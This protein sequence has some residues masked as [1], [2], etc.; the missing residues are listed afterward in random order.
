VIFQN[1]SPTRSTLFRNFPTCSELSTTP[2]PAGHAPPRRGW[3]WPIG[4]W[5]WWSFARSCADGLVAMASVRSPAPPGWTGRRL[6]CT[7][8][9]H[10]RRAYSGVALAARPPLECSDIC[11]DGQGDE[12]S[13][14]HPGAGPKPSQ[15]ASERT[16]R[17]ARSIVWASLKVSPKEGN[18]PS[19]RG[20]A[21]VRDGTDDEAGAP[22]PAHMPCDIHG[23]LR[24]RT[25]FRTTG[26]SRRAQS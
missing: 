18:R 7:Y 8:A 15:A 4:S 22:C 3:A 26:A 1:H 12:D 21:P 5:G 10:S 6:P 24:S 25:Y 14:G 13:R 20:P 16:P 23:R 19:W 9:Q 17:D 11:G 2:G